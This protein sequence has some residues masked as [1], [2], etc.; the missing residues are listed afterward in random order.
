M[1]PPPGTK[2]LDVGGLPSLNG[3]PGFWQGYSNI[4]DVTLVNL[5]GSF[6]QFSRAELAPFQ[7]IEADVCTSNSLPKRY[8]IVF[9]NSVIEHV[10]SDRRQQLFANFVKS[11]GDGF[12]VQTPSPLFP[13]EAHC[14]VPFWWILPMSLRKKAIIRWRRN[15]NQFLAQQ[16]ASTRPIWAS[17]LQ[18]LFPDCRLLTER[19]LGLP[20]SQIAY[21][22]A[23]AG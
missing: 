22:Q 18:H 10:G 3:V 2:I 23:D 7:L 13:V 8:D 4:F 14:D 12:W 1:K 21:R 6:L 15:G 20:K 16:M 9:S 11:A 19:L 5:P 17:Q